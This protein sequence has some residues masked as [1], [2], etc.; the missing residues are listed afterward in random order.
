[1]R[2][3]RGYDT[4]IG[5][6]GETLSGGQ[7]Q[8]IAIARAM[9]RNAPILILDEPTSSLDAESEALTLE[10]LERLRRGRTTFIIAHRLSTVRTADAIVVLEGGRVIERG[11]HEQLVARGGYYHRLLRLQFGLFEPRDRFAPRPA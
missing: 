4:V 9:V 11:T 6:R 3:P 7:R 5:E 2:Q 10:A 8:R 1:M